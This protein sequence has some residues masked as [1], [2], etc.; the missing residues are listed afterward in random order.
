M[1]DNEGHSFFASIIAKIVEETLLATEPELLKIFYEYLG[2]GESIS[3][4]I[5][6]ECIVVLDNVTG[7][8]DRFSLG[9][10]LVFHLLLISI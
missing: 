5:L 4:V 7:V 2:A 8:G 6:E 3:D 9:W 1:P 10:I